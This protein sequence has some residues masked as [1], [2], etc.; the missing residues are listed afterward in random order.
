MESI[1]QIINFKKEIE[2]ISLNL[3][4]IE[5]E[6]NVLELLNP[7]PTKI[8]SILSKGSLISY[9]GICPPFFSQ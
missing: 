6:L 5:S 4:K 1:A 9:F 2:Q 8:I 3:F 7:R